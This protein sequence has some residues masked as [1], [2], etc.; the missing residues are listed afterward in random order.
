MTMQIKPCGDHNLTVEFENE[1]SEAVNK[2][3]IQFCQAV[4]MSSI[5]GIRELVPSFRA[6]LIDYDPET[7]DYQALAEKLDETA[8]AAEDMPMPEPK[9]VEIPVCYGGEFGMDLDFVAEHSGLSKEEVIQLHSGQN[10]YV[11]MLGFV[12][13]FPYLGGMD[14]RLKTP[15][16]ETPR[17]KIP[18]G[19][20]GIA[21]EQT[22]VYPLQSPGGWQIIGR[23]PLPLWDR[24]KNEALL[25]A[26]NYVRFKPISK[27]EY[28]EMSVERQVK[29]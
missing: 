17:L 6:V 27:E 22:G 4:E 29:E 15:R 5:E 23:T 11:Y 3:V 24:E 16:L 12:A 25:S 2:K 28:E 26:G 14:K 21:D 19:S 20:V 7:V 10:Y 13:G 9:I 1:I 8:K 18:A